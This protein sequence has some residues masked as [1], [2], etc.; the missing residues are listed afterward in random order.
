[1]GATA[2]QNRFMKAAWRSKSYKEVAEK[3]NIKVGSVHV[4]FSDY[5]KKGI[6]LPVYE[7]AGAGGNRLNVDALKKLAVELQAQQ[8][9]SETDSEAVADSK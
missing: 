4:R 9:D 6:P 5:R 3:L 1:M 2:N 8:A 7:H